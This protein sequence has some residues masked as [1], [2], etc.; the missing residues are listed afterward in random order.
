MSSESHRSLKQSLPTT[1]QNNYCD[2]SIHSKLGFILGFISLIIIFYIGYPSVFEVDNFYRHSG[3]LAMFECTFAFIGLFFTDI[4]RCERI[5]F[6]KKLK[7]DHIISLFFAIVLFS[8]LGLIQTLLGR[9]N[10]AISDTE[11]D[12]LI[13]LSA[14]AEELF[15]RGFIIS[16]FL[17]FNK[18][19]KP[20][21]KFLKK[22]QL[23]ILP[24]IGIII[25]SI[26]FARLHVFRYDDMSFLFAAF[27]GGMILGFFYWFTQD[28]TAC[29]L[30]HFFINIT[31]QYGYHVGL[32]S[33][34][35]ISIYYFI[36]HFKRFL[37]NFP[38][39]NILE[40]SSY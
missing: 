37:K 34:G 14:P 16:I 3:I 18:N 23:S 32:I 5:Q 19:T 15:F 4:L 26:F 9:F 40:G 2:R 8:I 33:I 36:I 20:K 29:I 22:E 31:A 24:V 28:L 11:I 27:I 10:F 21:S 13:I 35:L 38:D 1:F 30:A 17:S 6:R 25:S 39:L 7:D 12:I